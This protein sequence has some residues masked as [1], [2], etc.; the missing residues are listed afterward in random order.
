VSRGG[1]DRGDYTE[2]WFEDVGREPSGFRDPDAET[3]LEEPEHA[4]G[5]RD[6]RQLIAVLAAVVALI[7]VGVG[8]AR[9]VSGGGSESA[10]SVTGSGTTAQQTQPGTTTQKTSTTTP[11]TTL[12]DN[13]TLRNGDTGA[14]VKKLQQ[15]LVTLGYDPG[16]P[17]GS[18]GPATEQAVKSF[19]AD[20][21]LSADGIAGPTTL[22]ALNDALAANG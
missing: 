22:G 12:P 4:T 1:D 9:V 8:I 5:P 17:D 21:G 18:F 14:N 13:V 3:W 19:Q 2:D 10:T 11:A 16:T 7:I 15:A 6:R 20:S